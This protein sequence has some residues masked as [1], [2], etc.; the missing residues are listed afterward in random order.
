M[1]NERRKKL[2]AI[3]TKLEIIEEAIQEVIDE[4]KKSADNIPEI[5]KKSEK[6]ERIQE[7]IR[8]LENCFRSIEN[9]EVYVHSCI[10]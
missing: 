8:D 6:G 3:E 4:T 1:E 7:I 9:I 10:D 5:L 2:E